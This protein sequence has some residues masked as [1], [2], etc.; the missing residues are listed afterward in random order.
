MADFDLDIYSLYNFWL[1]ANSIKEVINL[2]NRKEV[3]ASNFPQEVIDF[4]KVQ[5]SFVKIQLW[6]AHLYVVVEGYQE[7]KLED[8]NIDRLLKNVGTM[9]NLRLLRNGLFHF[10]KGSILTFNEKRVPFLLETGSEKWIH[11]LN[12]AFESFFIKK[13]DLKKRMKK[14]LSQLKE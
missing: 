2:G 10:Q 12:S 3:H 5:D 4:V 9:N 8:E 13:L 11:N 7:L 6:Y 14:T 1:V